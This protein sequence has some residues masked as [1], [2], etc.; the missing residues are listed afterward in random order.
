M[1]TIVS[2]I[3]I[4]TSVGLFFGYINPT[5]TSATGS[6]DLNN[7]SISELQS[8]EKDYLD[9]LSKTREIE[10]KRDG[11][12]DKLKQ[13]DQADQ[14][15]LLKL[16]PDNIDSVRLIIDVNDIASDYG[17]SLSN[18]GLSASG[19]PANNSKAPASGVPAENYSNMIGPD[20][21]L[22]GSM[23]LS[24]N[25]SGSYDNFLAFLNKLQRS[26]RVSDVVSLSFGGAG[27][28][29]GGSSGQV[30]SGSSGDT[31]TYSLKIRTY[32]LK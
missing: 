2:I 11:L 13:I 21:T 18:I 23:L 3:L 14:D 1:S 24:F 26:L 19:V 16:L 29:S 9:A 6:Q 7:K 4:A 27:G 12:L 20:T 17:M 32:H 22:Y 28:A 8:D 30:V 5:Y 10:L 25:V 15:K 31:Y